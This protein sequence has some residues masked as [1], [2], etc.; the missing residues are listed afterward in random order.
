MRTNVEWKRAAR[1]IGKA[2]WSLSSGTLLLVWVSIVIFPYL[3]MLLSSFKTG[4]EMF[5]IPPT[6]F[7][8]RPTLANYQDLFR[9]TASQGVSLWRFFANSFGIAAITAL[10]S[11][12]VGSLASYS[13]SRL[14]IRGGRYILVGLLVT[15]LFPPISIVIPVFVLASRLRLLDTWA[16]L[17]LV[18]G[19]YRITFAAW[20]MSGYYQQVPEELEDAALI[21]GCGA[22]GTLVRIIF[23]SV[24]PA[25]VSVALLSFIF[26]WNE[27]MFA[28]ILTFTP[29]AKTLPILAASTMTSESMLWGKLTSLGTLIAIPSILMTLLA[30]KYVVK[31]L[32]AG[33]VK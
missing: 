12:F 30:Q 17:V 23:P 13:L 31:G 24:T 16:I 25:L 19:A 14:R 20:M 7:P 10:L 26:S 3:W 8:Q 21:D 33:A 9:R 22:L 5:A 28:L 1:P 15:Q 11:T 18:Y 32:T 27:F 4:R 2:A 29:A 6:L